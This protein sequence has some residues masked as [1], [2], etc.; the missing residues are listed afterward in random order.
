MVC[1]FV[2]GL[3]DWW[4]FWAVRTGLHSHGIFCGD[5]STAL[6]AIQRYTTVILRIFT[7]DYF[8]AYITYS[9]DFWWR[10][11]VGL[12]LLFTQRHWRFIV[13]NCCVVWLKYRW[14]CAWFL[15]LRC[16]VLQH[17]EA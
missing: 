4:H 15:I 6:S 5:V 10:S 8:P 17:P 9:E 2:Y 16:L 12:D 7:A 11:I 14:A 3:S 1:R 13:E